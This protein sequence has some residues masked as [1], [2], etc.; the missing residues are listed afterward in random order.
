VTNKNCLECKKPISQKA[1]ANRKR[2]R[3]CVEFFRRY[4]KT[5]LTQEQI[6]EAK[7]LIGKMSRGDIAHEMGC[8]VASLGRAFRGTRLA[9]FNRYSINPKLVKQVCAYYEIHGRRKTQERFPEICI[10]SV[11][12]RYKQFKPRQSRWTD[13]QIIEAAKMAGLVS[14]KHQA[15]YFNRPNAR[16]CS[17]KVLYVKRFHA[18]P[19][20]FHGMPAFKAKYLV[21]KD[22]PFIRSNIGS[23]RGIDDRRKQNSK[24]RSTH[25][26]K[27]YLWCD[28]EKHLRPDLPPFIQESIRSLAQF[29]CWLFQSNDPKKQILKLIAQRNGKG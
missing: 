9:F 29:Q 20:L 22:C 21:T 16:A 23:F 18:A 11:V 26:I 5:S 8:S 10:R 13:S 1:H 7:K 3:K 12:E 28:M 14:F 27:L 6:H 25:R 2:C 19:K 4:P 17:I 15:K 24:P